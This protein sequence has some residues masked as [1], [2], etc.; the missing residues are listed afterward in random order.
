MYLSGMR[1]VLGSLTPSSLTLHP[2]MNRIVNYC[3][4]FV[5][6]IEKMVNLKPGLG[7][8]EKITKKFE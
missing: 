7:K 3:L 5:V 4:K 1:L 6:V 8:L 2:G